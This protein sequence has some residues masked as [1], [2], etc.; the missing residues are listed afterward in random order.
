MDGD[1][2]ECR[3][4]ECMPE[5][6]QGVQGAGEEVV[7]RLGDEVGEEE[8]LRRIAAPTAS[9]PRSPLFPGRQPIASH[10]RQYPLR[11]QQALTNRPSYPIDA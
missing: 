4:L 2:V 3:G 7:E 5:D 11:Y 6:G 8:N 10:W 9:L 1:G